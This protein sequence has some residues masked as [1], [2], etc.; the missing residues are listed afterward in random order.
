MF[1]TKKRIAVTPEQLAASLIVWLRVM[2]KY[3]WREFEKYQLAARE[4]R[5]G[6]RPDVERAV[7]EHLAGTIRQSAPR[8]SSAILQR[9]RRERNPAPDAAIKAFRGAGVF[10]GP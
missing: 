7:A 9:D 8:N 10:R 4:K 2:P 6:D 5:Q 3:V 1:C